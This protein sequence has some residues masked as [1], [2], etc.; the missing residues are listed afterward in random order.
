MTHK[1]A[2]FRELKCNVS[3]NVAFSKSEVQNP[4]IIF[5]FTVRSRMRGGGIFKIRAPA[6]RRGGAGADEGVGNI[7]LGLFEDSVTTRDS[8][9]TLK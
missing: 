1:N 7:G 9:L 2:T 8:A 3:R 6:R 4:L 5:F